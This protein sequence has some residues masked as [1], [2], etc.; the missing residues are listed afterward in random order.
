MRF[1]AGWLL[2][3]VQWHHEVEDLIRVVAMIGAG[4]L[5]LRKLHRWGAAADLRRKLLA[6]NVPVCVKCGYLLRGLPLDP[7][8]CPECGTA[9]SEEV[10]SI[11]E[12][13]APRAGDVGQRESPSHAA[14]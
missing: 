1:L 3:Y 4:F 14:D 9:F 12:K 10:I 6:A 2:S 13:A 8:R 5:V 7:G 11:L